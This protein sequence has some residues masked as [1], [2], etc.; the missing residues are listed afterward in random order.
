MFEKDKVV[1]QHFGSF[2]NDQVYTRP[3]F[4]LDGTAM[5][6]SEIHFKCNVVG[7]PPDELFEAYQQEE[8][9]NDGQNAWINKYTLYHEGPIPL[10]KNYTSFNE[11]ISNVIASVQ[12]E[13]SNSMLIDSLNLLRSEPVKDSH[14]KRNEV[15]PDTIT[16]K[17]RVAKPTKKATFQGSKLLHRLR[18]RRSLPSATG[19]KIES[20]TRNKKSRKPGSKVKKTDAIDEDTVHNVL[21]EFNTFCSDLKVITDK[22]G[23][24]TG[25][26]IGLMH[27]K[28]NRSQELVTK[29]M[30]MRRDTKAKTHL[31]KQFVLH[32]VYSIGD[33]LV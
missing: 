21:L 30:R 24:D 14:R 31:E 8:T 22:Y 20:D 27:G 32:S 1:C 10:K 3:L 26:S 16:S 5:E 17:S 2:N 25:V 9:A 12:N 18:K 33:H 19:S 13:S 28:S 23:I 7:N 6:G 4:S 15:A 29:Y 11:T